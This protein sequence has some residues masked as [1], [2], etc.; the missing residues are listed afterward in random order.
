MW[1]GGSYGAL[2]TTNWFK[3][4]FEKNTPSSNCKYGLFCQFILVMKNK[5][6]RE[7]NSKV[8]EIQ[9]KFDDKNKTVKDLKE[10]FDK[11]DKEYKDLVNILY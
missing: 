1:F 11:L 9:N 3:V 7:I 8:V 10:N 2:E 4:E 6:F 5:N